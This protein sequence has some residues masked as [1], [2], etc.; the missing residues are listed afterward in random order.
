MANG[1]GVIM[2]RILIWVGLVGLVVAAVI[3]AGIASW[4]LS[5]GVAWDVISV[6]GL[7]LL[8]F[9]LCILFPSA[10]YYARQRGRAT[11]QEV[12]ARGLSWKH[13]VIAGVLLVLAATWGGVGY[14]FSRQT[15]RIVPDTNLP[16][17]D[18]QR[19]L[20]RVTFEGETLA[21]LDWPRETTFSV[22][23]RLKAD[24][25]QVE[26]FRNG[27]RVKCGSYWKYDRQKQPIDL[28]LLGIPSQ[29]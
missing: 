25:L 24:E 15:V 12:G 29:P 19:A 9:Y 14:L 8:L 7:L 21:E 13:Y 18:M 6:V 10:R 4:Q 11:W 1:C 23:R 20:L 28:R 16:D 17:R 27:S 22:H 26:V 5:G 3:G 2:L